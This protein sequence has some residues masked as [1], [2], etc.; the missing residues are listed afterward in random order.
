MAATTREVRRGR[1]ARDLN[2]VRAASPV[3][4]AALFCYP[5]TPNSALLFMKDIGTPRLLGKLNRPML[6][7]KAQNK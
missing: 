3:G 1:I 2:M 7:L 5:Q 6:E 4:G